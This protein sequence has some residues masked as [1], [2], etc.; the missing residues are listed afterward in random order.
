MYLNEI[1]KLQEE[2]DSRIRI[3]HNLENVNLV[4]KKIL[5]FLVELGE[6]AN[7]TRCFKYWSKK[8]ASERSIILE[9]YVDGF[10][11]LVSIGIELNFNSIL[12]ANIASSTND[13][14]TEAFNIT[15]EKII[16]LK[17][18]KTYDYYLSL[19]STF[20]SLGESLGFS[21]TEVFEAY[22]Q[23]NEKNHKRQDSGY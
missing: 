6:L 13:D 14:L 2:L 5:S 20:L 15:Y 11:F 3:E 16:D 9:E 18:N 19:F 17:N 1:F 4:D 23:K 7:E 22:K 21:R 8:S 12:E 10:H